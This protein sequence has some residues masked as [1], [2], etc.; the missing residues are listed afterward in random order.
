MALAISDHYGVSV[1]VHGG[2]EGKK[3]SGRLV[4][5]NLTQA[6]D[7]LSFLLGVQYR[8]DEAGNVFFFGG[9]D[10]KELVVLPSYGL[11]SQEIG[12][13]FGTTA[14]IVGDKIVADAEQFRVSQM[15]TALEGL[16]TR[17]SLV[18]ELMVLD[19]ATNTVHRVNAWIDSF[20]ASA[21]FVAKSADVAANVANPIG[22]VGQVLNGGRMRYDVDLG[23]LFTLLDGDSSARIQLRQQAQILSGSETRFESGDVLSTPLITRE[24]ETGKDLV[25]RIERRTVG[26]RVTLGA[27]ALSNEWHLKLDLEDSGFANG[28]ETTTKVVAERRLTDAEPVSLLASFSRTVDERRSSAVPVLGT[29]PKIGRW[30]TKKTRDG[31]ERSLM[32][33]VRPVAVTR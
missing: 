24:P 28:A 31:R 22:Q 9:K 27:V 12:N 32:V 2:D 20:K 4:A 11:T 21:G 15:R 30:F 33:L 16:R 23:V 25:S 10:S 26:L 8:A 13:A 6:L 5:S 19:V 7:G 18:V 17:P 14:K 1:L 3:V 29:A